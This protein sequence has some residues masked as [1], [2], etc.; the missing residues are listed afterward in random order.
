MNGL[1]SAAQKIVDELLVTF[2]KAE[3]EWPALSESDVIE[4]ALR[5]AQ[6]ANHIPHP[7]VLVIVMGAILEWKEGVKK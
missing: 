7:I 3:G 5:I 6:H 1:S 2:D 4:I